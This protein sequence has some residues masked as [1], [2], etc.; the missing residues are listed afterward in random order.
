[1]S[2][3][4]IIIISVVLMFLISVSLADEGKIYQVNLFYEN[5]FYD[6]G[7]IKITDILVGF[8][9]VAQQEGNYKQLYKVKLISST[10]EELYSASFN[11][12]IF[13]HGDEIDPVTGDFKGSV[14]QLDQVNFSLTVPYFENGKTIYI[15]DS[16]NTKILAADV[17]SFAEV[18][19]DSTCEQDNTFLIVLIGGGLGAIVLVL[20]IYVIL[21]RKRKEGEKEGF[22]KLNEKYKRRDKSKKISTS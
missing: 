4:R 15:Y 2:M 10:N 17:S 14:V 18:C 11:I 5:L 1:M 21:K 13:V 7:K 8:G 19:S 3:K 9:F 12:P 6:N 20:I 22:D 16:N